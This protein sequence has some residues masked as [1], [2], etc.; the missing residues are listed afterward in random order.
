MAKNDKDHHLEER[1]GTWYFKSMVKGKRLFEPLSHSVMVARR[2]RD[3]R[4]KEIDFNGIQSSVLQEGDTISGEE[5][6]LFGD[7]V[8]SWSQRQE[9][10]IK[11]DQLKTSTWRDWKSILNS[12]VLPKWGDMRIKSIGIAQIEKFVNKL[13]CRP[14][15][16]NNILVPLRGIFKYAKRQGFIVENPMLDIE[17]LKVEPTDIHP[18]T[19]EEVQLFL[20]TVPSHYRNFFNV[21]FFTGMRFGE[22]AALKWSQVDFNRKLLMIRKTRVYGEEGRLKTKKSLRDI[23]ILP[24]VFEALM[25]QNNLKGR[26]E[27]VFRDRDGNLMTPDHIREVVWKPTL[28]KAGLAYRPPMQTRHTFATLMIDSGEG[29]GWVQQ[30]LGH[31][32]LQMIYTRYYSWV[33]KP[34]HHDGDAFMQNML[35]PSSTEAIHG[36]QS[37]TV[38]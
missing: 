19:F 38:I 5:E 13:K 11:K 20:Q 21:A 17:N 3:Q 28:S 23:Q 10:C 14:K 31:G 24:P 34:T 2:L 15:R 7:V 22:M 18:F 26:D 30:M 1:N 8:M 4:L 36:T 25:L 16:V 37:A 27:Y 9:D 32:S 12:H 29:L 6:M 33:K 35:L